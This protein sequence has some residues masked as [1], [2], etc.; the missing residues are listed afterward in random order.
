MT[1]DD[2]EVT[3]EGGEFLCEEEHQHLGEDEQMETPFHQKQHHRIYRLAH[4]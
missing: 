1:S 3:Q 2:F 4:R